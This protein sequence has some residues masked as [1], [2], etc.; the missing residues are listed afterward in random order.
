MQADP[1][2][3]SA[4]TVHDCSCLRQLAS[5]SGLADRIVGTISVF[6]YALL[7][8]RA[9]T[10]L[11]GMAGLQPFEVAYSGG[12]VLRPAND[13]FCR[14]IASMHFVKMRY[15]RLWVCAILVGNLADMD[16][17]YAWTLA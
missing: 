8:G 7:T 10:L 1:G 4:L 12:K 2:W 17:Q 13:I 15:V 6:Y 11:T 9:S 5:P 3:D 16:I 14:H